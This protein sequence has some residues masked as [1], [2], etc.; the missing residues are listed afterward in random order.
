MPAIDGREPADESRRKQAGDGSTDEKWSW[1]TYRMQMDDEAEEEV[2]RSGTRDE[3]LR[4]S[5]A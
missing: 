2:A 5:E 4:A 3:I 1:D